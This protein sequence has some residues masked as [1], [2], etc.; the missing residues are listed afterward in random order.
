VSAMWA[1][2]VRMFLIAIVVF[3]VVAVAFLVA[4]A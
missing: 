4:T 3:A 1:M 2:S